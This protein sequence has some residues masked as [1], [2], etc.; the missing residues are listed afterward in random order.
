MCNDSLE[1]VLAEASVREVAGRRRP[2]SAARGDRLGPRPL[3]LQ[4]GD[5]G[6][7]VLGRHALALQVE[8]DGA[9]AVAAGGERLRARRREAGVVDVSEPLQGS[10][11]LAPFVLP[12]PRALE[13]RLDVRGGPITV[14]QRADGDAQGIAWTRF[15]VAHGF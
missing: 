8:T 4:L 15:S 14:L 11:R 12:H 7:H 1:G 5:G 10:E 9:I 3:G 6:L 13:S 2:S